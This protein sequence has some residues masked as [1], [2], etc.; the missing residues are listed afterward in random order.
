MRDRI[1]ASLRKFL[2]DPDKRDKATLVARKLG[3]DPDDL[4]QRFPRDDCCEK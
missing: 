3:I 1:F 2:I 4:L